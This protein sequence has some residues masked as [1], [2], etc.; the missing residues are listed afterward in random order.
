MSWTDDEIDQ[1]V[2]DAFNEQSFE[3]R[4][5]F[6]QD[7]EKQLP[8]NNRKRNGIYLYSILGVITLSVILFGLNLTSSKQT[9]SISKAL[10]TKREIHHI[11]IT[12][13]IKDEEDVQHSS[14][15]KAT[16][17][18]IEQNFSGNSITNSEQ[19]VEI[20]PTY[21]TNLIEHTLD[22]Q[23]KPV[24]QLFTEKRLDSINEK[25]LNSPIQRNLSYNPVSRFR[26]WSET[27]AGVGQVWARDKTNQ[28][29]SNTSVGFSIGVLVPLK[30]FSISLGSGFKAV[31]FDKLS[32]SER[33]KIYGF[34]V[35]QLESTY[36]FKSLVSMMLPLGFHCAEGRH[37]FNLQVTPSVNVSCSVNKMQYLDGNKLNDEKG[38]ANVM[39]FSPFGLE[40]GIGYDYAVSE[41]LKVGIRGSVQLIKP[42]SSDRFVGTSVG[43]PFEGQLYLRKTLGH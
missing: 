34:G 12:T 7:I 5:E 11:E 20:P 42:L 33:A 8:I 40:T 32:I 43:T 26:F 22:S 37:S 25:P 9:I 3:F 17:Q 13:K 4:R 35:N 31:F 16:I 23:E 18:L 36:N 39:L 1:L 15:S 2:R 41:K 6:W 14:S 28:H 10:I 21:T 19:N 24:I 30:R 29:F 27:T 38:Y